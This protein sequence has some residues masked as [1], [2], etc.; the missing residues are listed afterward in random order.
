MAALLQGRLTVELAAKKGF[1]D[2]A[3]GSA[4]SQQLSLATFGQFV[5]RLPDSHYAGFRLKSELPR[6]QCSSP[7]SSLAKVLKK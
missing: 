1:I 4:S 2:T 7:L 5:D 6:S 3:Q